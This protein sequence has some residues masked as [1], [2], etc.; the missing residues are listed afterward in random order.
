MKTLLVYTPDDG[1]IMQRQQGSFSPTIVDQYASAGMKCLI[2][3]KDI[4]DILY[5]KDG[6]LRSR[7]KM[8][9]TQDKM[10]AIGDGKDEV[11]FSGIPPGATV[12]VDD[13][14]SQATYVPTDGKAEIS[15]PESGNVIVHV[16]LWPYLEWAGSITF[17]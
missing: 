8:S 1:R 3:E 7:P 11:T 10:E 9:I 13:G 16:A 2:L 5:V 6:E 14:H 12:L 17:K 15:S 4:Y